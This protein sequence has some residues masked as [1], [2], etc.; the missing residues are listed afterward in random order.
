MVARRA[1]NPKVIGSSP[2]PATKEAHNQ[3]AFFIMNYTVY[4]LF[5]IT[6]KKTYVG[7]TSN[8]NERLK[9]HNELGIKG[10]TIK[11]RPW[12]LIYKE[13]FKAKNHAMERERFFK[14]GK[15]REKI[16]EILISKGLISA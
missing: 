8:L 10:W 6:F 9:S 7:Y 3:W 5:S 13:E 11:Y 14:S 12:E 1:H 16:K 4:I 2:V 15:G